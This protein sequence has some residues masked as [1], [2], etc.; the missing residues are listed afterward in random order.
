MSGWWSLSMT[1]KISAGGG[2]RLPQL[3]LTAVKS[4]AQLVIPK[5][6]QEAARTLPPAIQDQSKGNLL[7]GR[8]TITTPGEVVRMGPSDPRH[9]TLSSYSRVLARTTAALRFTSCMFFNHHFAVEGFSAPVNKASLG[10]AVYITL[11]KS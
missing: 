2:N 4:T 9:L 11:S 10:F 8:K 3:H 7:P 5:T 1:I 6:A